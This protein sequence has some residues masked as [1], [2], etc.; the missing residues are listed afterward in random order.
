MDMNNASGGLGGIGNVLDAQKFAID[1][2]VKPVEQSADK[3][4][5]VGK[6]DSKLRELA[7]AVTGV[8]GKVDVSA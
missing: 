5:P 3:P 6:H 7:S 8:G 4:A 1:P 2:N